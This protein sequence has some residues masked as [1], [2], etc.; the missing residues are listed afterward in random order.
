[1]ITSISP[2]TLCSLSDEALWSLFD[3]TNILLEEL[4]LGSWERGIAL[5][6]LR[7]VQDAIGER[8]RLKATTPVR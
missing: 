1:M 5:A 3:E 6:N 2:E 7:V 8:R 4:P